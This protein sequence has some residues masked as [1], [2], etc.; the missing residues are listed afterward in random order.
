[1]Q[2]NDQVKAKNKTGRVMER[3][4]T[5]TQFFQLCEEIRN[6]REVLTTDRPT[7]TEAAERLSKSLGFPVAEGTVRDAQ[8]ATGI[9]WAAK[10][11]ARKTAKLGPNNAGRMLCY[12][13]HALYRKLGEEV[14]D[15]LERLY[16]YNLDAQHG[17]DTEDLSGIKLPDESVPS[18]TTLVA[19]ADNGKAPAESATPP[20]AP[21]AAAGTTVFKAG[22]TVYVDGLVN[23]PQRITRMSGNGRIATLDNN[24]EVQVSRLQLVK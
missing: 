1:M 10:P 15:Y 16:R 12:A 17:R 19:S 22:D 24:W 5:N 3:R 2:S 13:L 20:K 11:K 14:P 9:E 7:L 18:P 6:Q 23:K 21:V 8:K 4:L